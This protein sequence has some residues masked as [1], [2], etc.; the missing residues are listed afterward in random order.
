MP[1][2]ENIQQR[3]I[4][5]EVYRKQ[6]TDARICARC[7]HDGRWHRFLVNYAAVRQSSSVL[8]KLFIEQYQIRRRTQKIILPEAVCIQSL[9]ALLRLAHGHN[10][11]FHEIKSPDFL[12]RL[13]ATAKRYRFLGLLKWPIQQQVDAHMKYYTTVDTSNIDLIPTFT[14]LTTIC[15]ILDMNGA[16]QTLTRWL[17]LHYPVSFSAI[18]RSSPSCLLIPRA[19]PHALEAARSEGLWIIDRFI[20]HALEPLL[21][22]DKKF[23]SAAWSLLLHLVGQAGPS[24][25]FYSRI[26]IVNR[27]LDRWK[28]EMEVPESTRRCPGCGQGKIPPECQDLMDRF[29]MNDLWSWTQGLCLPCLKADKDRP[30]MCTGICP[31]LPHAD[32][33]DEGKTEGEGD[34][35]MGD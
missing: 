24:R 12:A 15:Y 27:V 14:S 5:H 1:R 6:P 3:Y 28:W 20:D 18:H 4:Y 7:S 23:H 22:T 17:L 33:E 26:E 35:Q 2:Q 29:N 13:T 34:D 19:I 32:S 21:C 11:D 30:W 9:E 8:A 25:S 10:N 16:F 31:S